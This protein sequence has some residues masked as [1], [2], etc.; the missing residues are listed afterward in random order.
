MKLNYR[1]IFAGVL[2]LMVAIGISIIPAAQ[3]ER[4][5]TLIVTYP[6]EPSQID[7]HAYFEAEANIPMN[8][9]YEY[10]FTYRGSEGE[11]TP[12]LAKSFEVSDNGKTYTFEL[13]KGVKFHTGEDFN[14]EAVA[15]NVKRQM[16]LNLGPAHFVTNYVDH[17]E[18]VDE[19]TVAFHMK[20]P[21]PG[22]QHLLTGNWGLKFVCPGAVKEHK[23]EDDPWAHEWFKDHMCGTG[24]YQ[25]VSYEPGQKLVVERFEDY[26]RGWEGKHFKKIIERIVPESS[27][28]RM[29]LERGKIDLTA[30]PLELKDIKALQAKEDI[31]CRA[32]PSTLLFLISVKTINAGETGQIMSNKKVRK[33]LAYAF[34][35]EAVIEDIMGIKG[36]RISDM[37]F[38]PSFAGYDP[39]HFVYNYDLEKAKELLA[40]AG[41][42]NGGFTLDL[43]W[44]E[45][46]PDF[47]R[48]AQMYQADLAK[49]GIKLKI[50]GDPAATFLDRIAEPETTP[51]LVLRP[52]APQNALS[53]TFLKGWTKS[54]WPPNGINEG[55]WSNPAFEALFK[56]ASKE[57]NK[58]DRAELVKWASKVETEEVPV[59]WIAA[60]ND[61]MC[62]TDSLK[63]IVHSPW[64]MYTYWPYD[65]YREQHRE[66]LKQYRNLSQARSGRTRV[67][68]NS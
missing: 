8:A 3:T 58:E 45:G 43:M 24:P 4:E 54:Q 57:L 19:Y 10:L 52:R 22:Y 36:T 46:F 12:L 15:W 23:T 1:T 11:F 20:E 29:L 60:V 50:H 13:R 53:Y 17:V 62:F 64:Y 38:L 68:L 27:T 2:V 28:Q 5:D 40:E 7:P 30:M 21:T 42:P 35:Y 49:L 18:V 39:K 26:W 33:A 61:V 67:S 25:F 59:I 9:V 6:F 63:G 14:A 47:P 65:L 32:D 51:D 31:T 66:Q 48:I 34:N 55:Y 41:Y 37:I 44:L 56:A 16:E